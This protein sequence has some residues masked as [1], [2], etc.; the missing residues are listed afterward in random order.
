MKRRFMKIIVCMTTAMCL[1]FGNTLMAGAKETF[2]IMGDVTPSK[3]AYNVK[4]SQCFNAYMS[5]TKPVDL[6][7]GKQYY[8][9]YTVDKVEKNDLSMNGLI[10]SQSREDEYPYVNG[11]LE[12]TE[13]ASFLMEEGYTYF[14]RI[15]ITKSGFDYIVAKAKGDES[16]WLEMPTLV[17]EVNTDCKYFGL[18]LGGSPEQR[19]TASL[20]AVLCYDEDGNDIGVSVRATG[21]PSVY[22]T[23]GMQVKNVGHYYEFSIKDT[24]QVSISNAKKTDSKVIYMAYT[25]ENVEKNVSDQAG[26]AYGNSPKE[27]YP[28]GTGIMTYTFCQESPLLHEG[29]E[30]LLRLEVLDDTIRTLVKETRNN[31]VEYYAFSIYVGEFHKE[32]G[33]MS[34]WFGEGI[35]TGMTADF[36]NFRCYDD[37][38]RNLGVQ[39]N[40]TNIDIKHYGELEDYSHCEAVYYC[41][42]NDIML[43]LDDECNVGVK[44]DKGEQ[45]TRWGTYSVTKTELTLNLDGKSDKYTYYYEFMTDQDDNKYVRLKDKKVTFVTESEKKSYQVT[46]VTA[47]TGYKVEK[48]ENPEM[49]GMTFD[50]WCLRDGTE[51]EFG[52]I[53][54]ESMTLYARY[55]D[56]NGHQYLLVDEVQETTGLIGNMGVTIGVCVLLLIV[57]AAGI[58]FI[59]KRRK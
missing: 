2:E 17:G 23:K 31:Q 51:Y 36:K 48:P 15:Q 41:K 33:Y 47:A 11:M 32:A 26:I 4:F 46:N 58:I 55:T 52:N 22:Q 59:T 56:G 1:L 45:E 14:Y 13:D 27:T 9:T 24:T 43:I 44:T 34:W 50:A 35:G 19:I 7:V 39:T 21:E 20:S 42:A 28:F 16:S 8:L 12:Y 10:V 57:T 40:K 6:S 25:L 49:D 29:S 54:T 30:Y 37:R 3:E 18:W 38:G 5:N 53:V